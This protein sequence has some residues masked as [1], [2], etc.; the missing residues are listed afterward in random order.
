MKSASDLADDL[1][2]CPRAEL[3]LGSRQIYGGA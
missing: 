2:D 3:R 1:A